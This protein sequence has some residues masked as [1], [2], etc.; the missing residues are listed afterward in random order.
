MSERTLLNRQLELANLLACAPTGHVEDV[1]SR[2]ERIAELV[3]HLHEFL[4]P[5]SKTDPEPASLHEAAMS[6][7]YEGTVHWLRRGHYRAGIVPHNNIVIIARKPNGLPAELQVER[8]SDWLEEVRT[9]C[10]GQNATATLLRELAQRVEE[11]VAASGNLYHRLVVEA[12]A[13][14]S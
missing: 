4:D 6:A 2:A 9:T 14:A 3:A 1:A 13:F 5:E 12:N 10:T 11:H 7:L 8:L